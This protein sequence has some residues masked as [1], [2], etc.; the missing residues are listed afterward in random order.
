MEALNRRQLHIP[1]TV[2]GNAKTDKHMNRIYL[3]FLIFISIKSFSQIDNGYYIGYERMCWI[4]EKGIKE[5]YDAPRKWYHKNNLLVSNDS[6]FIYKEPIIINRKD[7]LY[8]ASDGAFYYFSGK[9]F[10]V[11]SKDFITVVL[12]NC[13]YCAQ[14]IIVDSI[15]GFITPITDTLTYRLTKN[16]NDLVI[17]N[18]IY[19]LHP[20]E[21]FPIPRQYFN[22]FFVPDVNFSYR[23]NP[24]RQYDLI[25]QCLKDF[26]NQ[27]T[28]NFSDTVIVCFDRFDY[29]DK[30]ET[31]DVSFL[32]TNYNNYKIEYLSLDGIL[33][34]SEKHNKAMRYIQTGE[35]YDTKITTKISLT[36]K[37]CVPSKL[38]GF[39]DKEYRYEYDYAKD[40]ADY[41][42]IKAEQTGWSLI[43]K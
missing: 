7:T 26:L 24:L 40:N 38:K 2:G 3:I 34:L 20:F 23:R 19:S 10:N 6:I 11:D 13:D 16:E 31:L 35:I 15:S 41:K 27:D 37:I 17:N 21:S 25:N 8:S 33:A 12:T 32:N 39:Q 36:N 28:L 22:Q 29:N 4:N 14:K 42:L 1:P 18:V 9:I 43:Q 30:I 5:C